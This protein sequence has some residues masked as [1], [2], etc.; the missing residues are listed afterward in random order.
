MGV[1]WA[2]SA[3]LTPAPPN[4]DTTPTGFEI[5]DNRLSLYSAH[6]T[7]AHKIG[8]TTQTSFRAVYTG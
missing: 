5:V 7:K 6:L 2:Y 4:L 8:G 3:L 1:S